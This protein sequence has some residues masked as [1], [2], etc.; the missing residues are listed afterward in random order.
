MTVHSSAPRERWH[1]KGD[2][3]R[4]QP[5]TEEQQRMVEDFLVRWPSERLLPRARPALY[6]VARYS[7][8][9]DDEIASA[10]VMG[11]VRAAQTYNTAYGP[12]LR[13]YY[14]LPAIRAAVGEEIRRKS[15]GRR[16]SF[17][18]EIDRP[19]NRTGPPELADSAFLRPVVAEAIRHLTPTVRRAIELR[20]GFDGGGLRTVA[21]VA[22]LMDIS[23]ERVIQCLEVGC[24]N[25]KWRLGKLA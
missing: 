10:V 23:R 18:S 15:D 5:L 4:H 6:A 1:R 19:E 21:D 24:R 12:N 2:Q 11:V 22:R 25:L 7:N 9:M 16:L 8:L 13:L 3:R 20:F 17:G 14:A